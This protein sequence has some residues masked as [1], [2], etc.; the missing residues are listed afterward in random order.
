[1]KMKRFWHILK[2][3]F[4]TGVLLLLMTGCFLLSY[5]MGI[6]EWKTYDPQE[7]ADLMLS[8]EFFD[9]EGE[10]FARLYAEEDRLFRSFY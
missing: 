7:T 10:V 5:L 1:M 3:L 6:E 2:Y 4:L 9:N 8:S